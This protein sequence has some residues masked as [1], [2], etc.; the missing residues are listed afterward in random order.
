M[1]YFIKKEGRIKRWVDT[2]FEYQCKYVKTIHN[3][4]GKFEKFGFT[5]SKDEADQFKSDVVA[6]SV[7]REVGNGF[8]VES[9]VL[10]KNILLQI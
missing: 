1:I 2:Q 5:Y 3:A 10:P 6:R 4:E 7:A 8:L 9:R